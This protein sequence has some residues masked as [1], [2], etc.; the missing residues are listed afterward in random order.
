MLYNNQ[1][2]YTV[3][4][5]HPNKEALKRLLMESGFDP[6]SD[7]GKSEA[8]KFIERELFEY[9]TGGKY[10]DMFPQRWLPASIGILS[11]PFT[12]DNRMINST[13]KMVRGVITEHYHILID[14]LYTPEAKNVV[15]GRNMEEIR[16]LLG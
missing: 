1:K 9:R 12:E 8:L 11:E 2:P 5:L 7:E 6:A 3:V 10:S 13:T 16:K 4:L 14:Y 15:N